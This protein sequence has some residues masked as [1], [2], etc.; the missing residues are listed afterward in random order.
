[1]RTASLDDAADLALCKAV[2][3]TFPG[4]QKPTGEIRHFKKL[5]VAAQKYLTALAE[6]TGAR[7]RI[8]S[9]GPKRA[10]TFKV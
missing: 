1:M 2:Y 9:V 3:R 7:L 10:E 5:P 4:W 6:L 8:V